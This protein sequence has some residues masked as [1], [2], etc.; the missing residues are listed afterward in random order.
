MERI[1]IRILI[2]EFDLDDL[3]S[4]KAM[5]DEL[6]EEYKEVSIEVS[7]LPSPPRP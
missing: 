1:I 5:L 2:E 4:V 3:K 7:T 6:F